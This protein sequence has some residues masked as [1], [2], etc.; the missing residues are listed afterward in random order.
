MHIVPLSLASYDSSMIARIKPN[1]QVSLW[2]ISVDSRG[3]S[4]AFS[5]I[6]AALDALR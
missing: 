3:Q 4:K 2:G 1:E 5:D 6:R